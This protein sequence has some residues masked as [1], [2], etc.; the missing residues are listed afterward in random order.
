MRVFFS[1]DVHEDK[2]VKLALWTC[3]FGALYVCLY[4]TFPY[5]MMPPQF[6]LMRKQERIFFLDVF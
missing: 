1:L 5:M 4:D 6:R 3:G 2:I